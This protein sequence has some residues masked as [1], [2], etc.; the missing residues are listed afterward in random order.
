MRTQDWH[1]VGRD[2]FR[3]R[4]DPCDVTVTAILGAD[5]VAVV[6]TRCSPA[7]AREVKDLVRRL[8]PLP[9]RWVVNTHAHFD[10]SWGNA[11]F[12]APRL[13]PPARI[14][15]HETVPAR[16]TW[17]DPG[18][19]ELRALMAAEGPE[20][21]DTL[22]E[23]EFAHPTDLVR[24][25]AD[26]DLGGGRMLELRH[27]GRGHTD[28]DLWIRVPD[29]GVVLA[30]DQ[31][32]QSGPPAFGPDSFPLDWPAALARALAWMGPDTVIVP[33]HGEPVDRQFVEN[34]RS[35]IETIG[36]EAVR[37]HTAEVPIAQAAGTGTWPVAADELGNAVE[38]SYAALAQAAAEAGIFAE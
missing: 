14:W 15:A 30:G 22:A 3:R 6:D 12:V 32:E 4:F 21:A 23:V 2:V 10:H 7:E 16:L 8:T 19:T 5:G 35:V 25:A 37:L 11:E 34:Q 29:A 38:R 13:D 36:H 17:D 18:V 26:L 20:W 1:E 9:I 28:G 33:G 24:H 31:V 27:H